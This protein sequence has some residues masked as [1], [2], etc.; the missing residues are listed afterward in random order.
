MNHDHNHPT[1]MF[2]ETSR[3]WITMVHPLPTFKIPGNLVVGSSAAKKHYSGEPSIRDQT[4]SNATAVQV[5]TCLSHFM[6]HHT[7]ATT[8][9]VHNNICMTT[10]TNIQRCEE[11]GCLDYPVKSSQE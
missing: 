5:I 8:P 1:Y 9:L 10:H 7:E 6:V 11:Q 2:V 4:M 3:T